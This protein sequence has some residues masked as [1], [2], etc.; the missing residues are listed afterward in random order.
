MNSSLDDYRWLTSDDAVMWLNLAVE[1]LAAKTPL[2]RLSGRL[3][4][5]LSADRTHLVLSQV[6]LRQR[7]R[8]KFSLT[9]RMFFTPLGLAQATDE[10][11]ARYKAARFPAD[12]R[13]ADLCC[14]VGGDLIALAKGRYCLGVDRDPIA[15]HLASANAAVYGLAS[16]QIECRQVAVE[17]IAADMTWHIDPDRRPEGKRTV[18]AER[19][20]PPWETVESLLARCGN[21]GVKLAPATRLAEDI[22]KRCELE[23]IE[24]RGECRQQVA[25]FGNLA[26]HVG[27]HVATKIDAQ[28]GPTS[29]I[30]A[31]DE[32]AIIAETAGRFVYEPGAAVRAAHLTGTLARQTGL[33]ELGDSRYLTGDRWIN[34]PLLA[35]FEVLESLPFDLRRLK[36][37]LRHAGIGPLEVKKRG[38]D[39]DPD[40]VRRQLTRA[41]GEPGVVLIAP[42]GAKT[43]AIVAR[44][45]E[46]PR[47]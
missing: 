6:D 10:P 25:W 33:A 36:E 40:R 12:S 39:V 38:A 44:R 37:V 23:W 46:G 15:A 31:S 20:E 45:L 9:D 26:R 32:K 28:G 35:C 18:Q 27:K 7:G 3:R 21:A 8:Q 11:L 13:V 43:T 24:S 42:I 29:V 47:K 14:G 19:F 2:V 41:D 22:A 16:A 1:E 34:H 30:G 5:H 17:T 4:K